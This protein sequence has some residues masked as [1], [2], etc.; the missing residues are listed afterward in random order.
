MRFSQEP[1]GVGALL[2]RVCVTVPQ[3]TAVTWVRSALLLFD[4]LS[5]GAFHFPAPARP[6]QHVLAGL[7]FVHNVFAKASPAAAQQWQLG[8][9]CWFLIWCLLHAHGPAHD[10]GQQKD[11]DAGRHCG[12]FASGKKTG[13]IALLCRMFTFVWRRPKAVLAPACL[14]EFLDS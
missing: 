10:G 14:H 9:L 6:L 5:E 8:V 11:P 1:W 13:M 7:I 2:D 12:Y 3:T 4:C